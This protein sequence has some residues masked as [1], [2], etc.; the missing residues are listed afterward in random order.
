MRLENIIFLDKLV[1]KIFYK[2]IKI[3]SKALELEFADKKIDLTFNDIHI[4]HEISKYENPNY[5]LIAG[6]MEVTK[7]TFSTSIKRLLKNNYV[8]SK[9]DQFDKRKKNIYLTE[10]G[11]LINKVYLKFHYKI[12]A[13]LW[14]GLT[15]PEQDILY[16][17]V[18]NLFNIFD[19]ID[20][21]TD[22]KSKKKNN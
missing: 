13:S 5:S 1:T 12:I 16:K 20:N 21:K 3:E 19:E 4:L 7:G 17:A 9:N 8:I 2:I 10:K 11:Q 18:K 15:S 6:I 14:Q 22:L